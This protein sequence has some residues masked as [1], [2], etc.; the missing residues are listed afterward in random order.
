MPFSTR[1]AQSRNDERECALEFLDEFVVCSDQF[2]LFALGQ[3]DIHAIV[4]TDS[5]LRGNVDGPEHERAWAHSRFGLR[6]I[7]PLM[8]DET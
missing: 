6:K 4:D 7:E 2:A 8:A 1:L 5:H 3:C